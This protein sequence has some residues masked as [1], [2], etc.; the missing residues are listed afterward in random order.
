MSKS[1]ISEPDFVCDCEE[2]MRSACAGGPYYKEH[3]GKRYCLLHFPGKEKREAFK[4]VFQRKLE[5]KDFNFRGVWFPD[6]LSFEDYEFRTEAH[7]NA[8]TFSDEVYFLNV[9]FSAKTYF[10]GATFNADAYFTASFGAMADF[11]HVTF[12][13]RA[14]FVDSTFEAEAFFNSAMFKSRANF[15]RVTF[16]AAALFL[17]TTFGA[18]AVFRHT[19]FSVEAFFIRA[20]FREYVEFTG[21]ETRQVFSETSS[22]ELHFAKIENPAHV[23]FHSVSLRPHWFVNVDASKFDFT[24]VG[25]PTFTKVDSNRRSIKK[26]IKRLQD[27]KLR[28][29]HRLLSVACW[30]L[31]TNAEENHRYPEA[32]GFRYMA[33]DANRLEH[34]HGFAFWRLS[35]WYWLASG[36]SE[37]ILRATVVLIGMLLLTAAIYTQVGF[38]GSEPRLTRES[39][40]EATKWED[41][42]A[43]LNL[44]RALIYS[45]EVMAFQKP[46]PKPGTTAAHSV[47]L[48]ETILGP[49][50]A[51]L[52]LLAI[53][54]K[55]MR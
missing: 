40:A 48:L 43:R 34:W 30:R 52:L 46:E 16:S 55:F 33:M 37:R 13:A 17:S 42:N 28:F 8:A 35:W 44:R 39:R 22:L 31:A 38:V 5:N 41:T 27:Q 2:W 1:P 7:F 45:A 19:I 26:E 54:R 11:S 9:T 50:Q 12:S 49:V 53:R 18:R 3:E 14:D 32:S 29:P 6:Q 23:S 36:Y 21:D 20:A 25:W 15:N 47:V 51:A 24:N 10:S 4:V